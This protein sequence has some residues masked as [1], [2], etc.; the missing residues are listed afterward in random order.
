E[1]IRASA[2]G[3]GP[4]GCG[5][6]PGPLGNALRERGVVDSGRHLPNHCCSGCS[7]FQ[8]FQTRVTQPGFPE[9]YCGGPSASRNDAVC[10]VPN[11]SSHRTFTVSP[12]CLV[13]TSEVRRV[14]LETDF[15]SKLVSRSPALIPIR[16]IGE[17]ATTSDTT[18]PVGD[19]Q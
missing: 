16:A 15:P 6:P 14:G 8:R 10:A 18:T 5:D 2:R 4:E 11:W 1:A 3:A 9:D 19:C 7:P 17:P 12:G 13:T